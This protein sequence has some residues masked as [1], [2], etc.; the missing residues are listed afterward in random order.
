M[1]AFLPSPT[2]KTGPSPTAKPKL[3]DTRR[4]ASTGH[5]SPG[6]N[7]GRLSGLHS[8]LGTPPEGTSHDAPPQRTEY[9]SVS[10]RLSL[11]EEGELWVSL[12]DG[13]DV[14]AAPRTTTRM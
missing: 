4:P 8:V 13:V 5:S 11:V 12:A 6:P 14:P 9:P 1:T 10:R 7:V 2:A 3:L